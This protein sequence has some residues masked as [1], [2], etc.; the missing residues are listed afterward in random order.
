MPYVKKVV[1]L[2]GH[3]GNILRS[4]RFQAVAAGLEPHELRKAVVS[5]LAA[6]LIDIS[7]IGVRP[8]PPGAPGD[9]ELQWQLPGGG[10]FN[11]QW[12]NVGPPRSG[13]EAN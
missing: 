7:V 5:E 8:A 6:H 1:V 11:K 4:A 9:Y 12:F 13:R 3:I 2:Q 10:P